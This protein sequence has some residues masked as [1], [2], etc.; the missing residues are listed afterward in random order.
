MT[1]DDINKMQA[2][3]NSKGVNNT[4]SACGR[5]NWEAGGVIAAPGF[6]SGGMTIGGPTVPMVTLACSNCGFVRLFAAVPIGLAK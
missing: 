1:Q 6:T 4:C 2:W 3:F 5:N